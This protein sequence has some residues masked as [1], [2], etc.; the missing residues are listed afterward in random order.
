MQVQSLEVEELR[1]ARRA[2]RVAVVTET[3]PPEVNGVALT[4]AR[5]VECLR[6]GGHDIELVRPRQ[7]TDET[8]AGAPGIENV[9][10]RG[11]PIPRY[12]NLKMGMP[13]KRALEARWSFR[14]P[15]VVHIVT[16]GPLGWSALRAALK[17]RLPV[18]SDFRTNFHA[19]SSHY[20]IGWLKKPILAYLRKFHNRTL[21]TL[22]PTEALRAEL[23]ALGFRGLHVVARGVDTTLFDP[24]RRCERL[25]ASW[26]AGP[27][28]P[29]LLHV[30]RIAPEKNLEALAAAFRAAKAVAPRARLVLVGD[31][32]ARRSF[33]E[34][35]PGAVFAGV[36]RG[37]ELAAHYASGDLFLFPSLTETYG[38]VTLEALASGL[39]VVA[40]DY[41]AARALIRNGEN[42]LAP[43][44]DD[45]PGFVLAAAR[46]AGDA[47]RARAL[48]EAGRR[49]ALELDWAR[50]GRRLEAILL[51]A[52]EA[53]TAGPAP[54]PRAPQPGA[55]LRARGFPAT[56][57]RPS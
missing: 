14:R 4:A 53:A 51:S 21:A 23:A 10:T 40:Y 2:L 7:D 46:L 44:F 6:A 56:T 42:G 57:A 33:E 26:G 15:D 54:A 17:L 13:A 29:V 52:A 39:A 45:M 18:V 25:R 37:E 16:E 24:A 48:G 41:A 31:G 28:D 43:A 3:Y 27:G 9:L 11:V 34:R 19:Y 30:G 38:N 1:A 47:V 22:V 49:S 50:V 12:P 20:G 5:F 8:D 35:C 32:P 55:R 36:R